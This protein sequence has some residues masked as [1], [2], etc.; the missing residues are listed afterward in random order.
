M[1]KVDIKRHLHKLNDGID[2][3]IISMYADLFIDYQ[4]AQANIAENGTVVFHP[5]TGAP[6]MNPLLAVRDSAMG[7]LLKMDLDTGDLWSR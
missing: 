6:V 5:K 3:S 4:H 2:D 1:E 7:R